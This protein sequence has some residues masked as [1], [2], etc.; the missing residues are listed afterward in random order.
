MP[1][2]M[3]LVTA[4]VSSSPSAAQSKL[5]PWMAYAGSSWA[6]MANSAAVQARAGSNC[7]C[8]SAA[9]VRRLV[10]RAR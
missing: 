2:P 8:I 7:H 10:R 6:P 1:S 3:P 5:S 4:R 9:R